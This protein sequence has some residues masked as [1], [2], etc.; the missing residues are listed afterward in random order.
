MQDSKHRSRDLRKQHNAELLRRMRN[1]EA[2]NAID[3]KAS[4][5]P[6][7]PLIKKD[8]REMARLYSNVEAPISAA[9]PAASAASRG[10]VRM[11]E[12]DVPPPPSLDEAG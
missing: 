7:R 3:S 2:L 4:W 9:K 11:L 1:G 6:P 5:Y 8:E 10:N 12:P